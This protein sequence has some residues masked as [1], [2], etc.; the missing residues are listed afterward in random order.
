VDL[1]QGDS[2]YELSKNPIKLDY[3][4]WDPDGILMESMR[5]QTTSGLLVQSSN[6]P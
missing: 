5:R 1:S 3:S 4:F 6:T 2:Q